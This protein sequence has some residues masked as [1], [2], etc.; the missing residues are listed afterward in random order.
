MR[1]TI[2]R[3]SYKDFEKDNKGHLNNQS[4]NEK[5]NANRKKHGHLPLLYLSS[6]YKRH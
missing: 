3:I 1:K 4:F 6:S 5:W 2:S